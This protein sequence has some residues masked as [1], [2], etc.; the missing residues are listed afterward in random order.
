MN[1]GQ[2]EP[3]LRYLREARLRNPGSGELRFHLAYAL[4]KAGRKSEAKEELSAGLSGPGRVQNSDE[5]LTLK[6]ELGL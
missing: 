4:A 1:Q 6:K 5:V 3:G 2:I